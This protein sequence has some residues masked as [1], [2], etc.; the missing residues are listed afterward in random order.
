MKLFE[1]EHEDDREMRRKFE[2]KAGTI[3]RRVLDV[4]IAEYKFFENVDILTESDMKS[5]ADIYYDRY[6]E[7]IDVD[8]S[9][10]IDLVIS[11]TK[12]NKQE[13]GKAY[14][15]IM[16]MYYNRKTIMTKVVEILKT[17]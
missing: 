4:V 8:L 17:I 1:N 3:N 15:T 13:E 5:I 9:M 12:W 10:Y 2:I 7:V 6:E 16:N 14:N 11:R